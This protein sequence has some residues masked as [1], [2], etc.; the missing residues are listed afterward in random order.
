MAVVD[1][2]VASDLTQAIVLAGVRHEETLA[3]FDEGPKRKS[4]WSECKVAKKGKRW[5]LPDDKPY[6][7]LPYVDLPIGLTEKEIDQFLREQRLEDLHRKIQAH[8]LEDVDSD[9][10]APSPPPVYDKA[11][12]RMNTRDIRIRKTMTA[13]YNRLIRYMIK[14]VDNYLPP[15]DWKPAKLLKKIIIPIEKFPQAPFMGVIIGPRGVNHKRLQET[16]GC[17]IFIRGRDI[18]DKWQTE[19]EAAMHQHVHIEGDTEEQILVAERLIEPLLNP[20]SPEFEYARTHGMQQLAMV[21]G[22]TLNKAE[23]RCGICGAL[24]HLGFECPETNNQNY[25]MANVTC[26]ICGDKGHVAQDCKKQAEIN[27]RETTEWKTQAEKKEQIDKNFMD[28]MNDLG[29]EKKADAAGQGASNVPKAS[30]NAAGMVSGQ[31]FGV[32]AQVSCVDKSVICPALLVG[33]IIGP[34]GA[35]IKKL[36]TDTGAQINMDGGVQ[37]NGGKAVIITAADPVVR[38]RAKAHVQAWINDN[39][40][41][42]LNPSANMGNPQQVLRPVNPVGVNNILNPPSQGQAPGQGQSQGQGQVPG[43]AQGQGQGQ[44]QGPRGA[45]PTPARP[46]RQAERPPMRRWWPDG[47]CGMG[48]M[49]AQAPPFP[50]AGNNGSMGMGNMGRG[51]GMGMGMGGMGMG[52]GGGWGMG[53]GMGGLPG[54]GGPG[55]GGGGP[56]GAGGPGAG[57]LGGLCQ[58]PGM[59]Q[60]QGMGFPTPDMPPM[61][62]GAPPPLPPNFN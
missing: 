13:E 37:P 44:T 1:D 4:R 12:N 24:G 21:N 28:M 15:V 42:N 56:P 62:S 58:F 51:Y 38:E 36:G 18:G 49:R 55:G 47:G 2:F 26:T 6:R 35:T 43:Q 46:P 60:F 9:I 32:G 22:F 31:A 17:K 57:Q 27:R 23:Q 19:E 54:A 16:T 34:A 50:G 33:K 53:P 14:H 61:P 30:P 3:T 11:G 45:T 29:N 25:K 52:M 20:E 41:H 5:G 48:G 40:G 8:E 59:Q 7:P 10:R 39:Q